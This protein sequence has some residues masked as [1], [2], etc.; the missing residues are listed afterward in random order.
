[1]S[2]KKQVVWICRHANRLDFVDRSYR[3]DDPPISDDGVIQAQ[4]TGERLKGEG[5]SR[6]FAS[7]FLRTIQ[8]AHY[9]AEALDLQVGIEPGL[10]EWLNAD[11]FL[12]QPSLMTPAEA[13][14]EYPRINLSYRSLIEVGFPEDSG[15]AS[16]RAGRAARLLADSYSDENILLIGHGHSVG[17][18]ATGIM[19]GYAPVKPGL[20]ALIKIVR[21]DGVPE[22]VL[23]GDTSHLESGTLHADRMV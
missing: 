5:I 11:W 8:T 9:I 12:T 19:G 10:S 3:G 14:R 13:Q 1:V 15:I 20:C 7:P 17:G 23:R 22:L 16:R 18:A 2:K 6:I 4:Q 21:T